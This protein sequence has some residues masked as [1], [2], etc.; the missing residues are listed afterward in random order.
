[1]NGKEP[2]ARRPRQLITPLTIP[3]SNTRDVQVVVKGNRVDVKGLG[4]RRPRG[5]ITRLNVLVLNT[6]DI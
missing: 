2:G 1:M 6:R 4:A 5:L 3:V